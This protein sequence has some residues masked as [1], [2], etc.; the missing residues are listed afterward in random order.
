MFLT[1][2]TASNDAVEVFPTPGVPVMRTFGRFLFGPSSL[3]MINNNNKFFCQWFLVPTTTYNSSG[4]SDEQSAR[5]MVKK[6]QS[7]DW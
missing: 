3:M 4:S 1:N 7:G 2:L 5:S 6:N